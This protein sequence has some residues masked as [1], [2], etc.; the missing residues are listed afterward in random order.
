MFIHHH[1][2]LA[3]SMADPPPTA[4]MCQAG[5][6][7]FLPHRLWQM[8]GWVWR[9][10]KEGLVHNSHFIQLIRNRLGV[11]VIVQEVIRYINA[12]FLPLHF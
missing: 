6:P 9:H 8:Q 1:M 5:K 2:I 7:A 12:F 10:I 3:A 11:A 4:I